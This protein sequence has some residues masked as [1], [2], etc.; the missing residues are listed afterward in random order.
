MQAC[1]ANMLAGLEAARPSHPR[2]GEFRESIDIDFLVSD[3]GRYRE[4]RQSLRGAVNLA[5]LTRSGVASLPLVRELRMD[6]Y[7]LRGFV[8]IGSV[9]IKLEIVS[10]GR[11][12]FA[13]PGTA[14][15]VCGV[16]TLLWG[17]LATS[18][19]LTNADR[20]HDASV[21][22]R[23][24]IDLAFMELPPRHLA[25]ALRKATDAYGRTVAMDLQRALE[26]LRERDGRLTPCISVLSIRQPPASVLQ[27][28][29]LLG[30][31]L[32]AASEL[33]R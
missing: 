8:D 32:A 15:E 25:P 21:F 17:D 31:R 30:H 16:A 9:P 24:V 14:D 20:W 11:V 3:A 12:M 18:K 2:L 13:P 1:Y 26:I 19:L 27:K 23:D 10:E 5:S 6:Q 4:L 29:R 33:T 28:L 7:G 22:S